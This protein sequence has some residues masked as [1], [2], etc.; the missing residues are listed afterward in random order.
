MA[1]VSNS[2]HRQPYRFTEVLAIAEATLGKW[3]E[4][5]NRRKDIFLASKFGSF[6]LAKAV[7]TFVYRL[8]AAQQWY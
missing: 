1:T 7:N 4:S 2:R 8:V 5:T 6:D 3:F